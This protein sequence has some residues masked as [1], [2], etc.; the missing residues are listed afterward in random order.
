[1]LNYYQLLNLAPTASRSDIEAALDKQY[2]LGT[3]PPAALKLVADV[4]L[5]VEN[6]QLYDEK[7]STLPE[8]NQE[9]ALASEELALSHSPSAPTTPSSQEL[10][11]QEPPRRTTVDETANEDAVLVY[12]PIRQPDAHSRTF[13]MAKVKHTIMTSPLIWLLFAV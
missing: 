3:L 13:S 7:L 8:M 10:P 6:R 9:Y 12:Q 1:M 5:S 4:L 2:A 11:Y